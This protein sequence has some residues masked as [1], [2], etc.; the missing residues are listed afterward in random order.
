[1]PVFIYPDG[2]P[3]WGNP[4]P[5]RA[6]KIATGQNQSMLRDLA[7]NQVPGGRTEEI[8]ITQRP[9]MRQAKAE[10]TGYNDLMERGEYGTDLL[11]RFM[12]PYSQKGKTTP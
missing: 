2:F 11:D 10:G 12:L 4:S 6:S 1:M 9:R 7:V 8:P 3:Y 5:Q